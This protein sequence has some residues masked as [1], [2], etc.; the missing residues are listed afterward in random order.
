[1]T[2]KCLGSEKELDSICNDNLSYSIPDFG[3]FLVYPV[4]LWG[5]LTSHMNVPIVIV[6]LVDIQFHEV[7]IN[8]FFVM[9]VF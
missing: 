3:V 4:A 9:S 5:P 6:Y 2:V 7:E 1:M 8:L